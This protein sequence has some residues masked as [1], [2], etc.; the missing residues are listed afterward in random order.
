VGQTTR[1]F[2]VLLVKGVDDVLRTL[3][4]SFAV[5]FILGPVEPVVPQGGYVHGLFVGTQNGPVELTAYAEVVTNGQLR[6]AKGSFEN[7]PT[8]SD[9]Q[10]VLCNLP[11]WEPGAIFVATQEIFRNERAERREV[12]FA[13]RRLNISALELRVED[14]ERKDRLGDLARSVGA[15]EQSP[16]YVFIVMTTNG[17]NR[18]YPFRVGQD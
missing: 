15:S 10:R 7:V 14:V 13:L 18:F 6:M 12:R 5:A 16:A 4:V 2:F 1:P 9:V 3:A 8:L 11:N 17:L